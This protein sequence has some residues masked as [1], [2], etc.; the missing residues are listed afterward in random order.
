MKIK[1][2]FFILLIGIFLIPILSIAITTS[3]IYFRSVSRMMPIAGAQAGSFFSPEDGSERDEQAKKYIKDY[4]NELPYDVDC[5]VLSGK[6]LVLYSEMTEITEG[7]FVTQEDFR[8]F[9]F[10]GS[11]SYFYSIDTNLTYLLQNGLVEEGGNPLESEDFFFFITRIQKRVEERGPPFFKNF[12]L[13]FIT[14]SEIILLFA[15]I[16][17]VFI[18][19]QITISV[20]KLK[21]AAE[22]LEAGNLD[23]EIKLKATNEIMILAECLDRM[24]LGLKR[25]K[26]RNS[27]FIVGLSH[28]LRTPISLIKGYTEA[29]KDNL[30][31]DPQFMENALDIILDKT[32]QLEAMLD[33]LIESV[34]IENSEWKGHLAECSLNLWLTGF[35]ARV[36]ADGNLLGKQIKIDINL[37][38]NLY[39]MVDIEIFTRFLENLISNAFRYTG[40]G[41]KI[42]F[43]ASWEPYSLDKKE[44]RRAQEKKGKNGVMKIVVSD[45]GAGISEKSLPFIFDAF[46][47]EANS[48]REG[49]HGFGLAVVKHIADTYGWDIAV[50]SKKGE[51]ATF[52]VLIYDCEFRQ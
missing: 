46:Y 33:S 47:K 35:G 38:S 13:L 14:V 4:L 51:G 37:P 43:S 7:A 16:L 1:K 2:L 23:Q 40:E 45:D 19:R 12:F 15:I 18:V 10:S 34:R 3:M 28:D 20:E 50:N 22:T 41:G 21:D 36:A 17:S 48:R 30:S 42:A 31:S 24:R 44:R 27:N 6:G 8:H 9:V 5:A 39:M 25:D 29:I 11:E 26:I 49:G 52:T 32:G